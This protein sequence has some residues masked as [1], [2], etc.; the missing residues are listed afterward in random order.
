MHPDANTASVSARLLGCLADKATRSQVANNGIRLAA[1]ILWASG[2]GASLAYQWSRPIPNSLKVIHS[3]VYAQVRGRSTT[4]TD[5][6]LLEYLPSISA[7]CPMTISST[8]LIITFVVATGP[9]A[10]VISSCGSHR[11]HGS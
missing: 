6:Q 3:R 7:H 4:L 2:L 9:D 1:G 5:A 8:L 11:A 10:G